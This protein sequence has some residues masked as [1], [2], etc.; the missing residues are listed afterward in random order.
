MIQVQDTYYIRV[1]GQ[2]AEDAVGPKVLGIETVFEHFYEGSP[3]AEPYY[4]VLF[5]LKGEAMAYQA[6]LKSLSLTTKEKL[7]ILEDFIQANFELNDGGMYLSVPHE[8]DVLKNM[9]PD[10]KQF[11]QTVM[12]AK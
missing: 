3:A 8:T 6:Y 9:H 4:E 7:K 11:I 2:L 12:G 10:R 5:K 1:E